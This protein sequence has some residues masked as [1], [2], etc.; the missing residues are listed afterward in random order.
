MGVAFQAQETAGL[1]CGNELGLGTFEE[2][3]KAAS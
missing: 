3:K 2:Q 1:R